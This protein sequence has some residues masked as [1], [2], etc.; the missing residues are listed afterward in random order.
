MNANNPT[1]RPI[2]KLL[3]ALLCTLVAVSLTTVAAAWFAGIWSSTVSFPVQTGGN[4]DLLPMTVWQYRA[5][6]EV[7]QD[8]EVMEWERHTHDS[9]I[10][11]VGYPIDKPGESLDAN[12]K[13]VVSELERLHFGR[14]DNLISLNEDNKIYFCFKLSKKEHGGKKLS[15]TFD[16]A[17]YGTG[18]KFSNDP[19]HSID[20][21]DKDGKLVTLLPDED[22]DDKID[23]NPPLQYYPNATTGTQSQMMDFLQFTYCV[24]PA[25]EVEVNFSLQDDSETK[26]TFLSGPDGADL[27]DIVFVADEAANNSYKDNIKEQALA[28]FN[29]LKFVGMNPADPTA[30]KPI[31]IGHGPEIKEGEEETQAETEKRYADQ[32]GDIDISGSVGTGEFYYLYICMTPNL[33]TY[34]LHEN[35]LEYFAQSYMFFDVTFAFEVQ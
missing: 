32:L 22:N 6:H 9:D 21:Y 35:I 30:D 8:D 12:G 25:S 1:K 11:Q 15:F 14:I 5:I 19:R 10:D 4:P 17:D 26:W 24:V 34:G 18:T 23:E 28:N 16:Y 7:N 31:Q 27:T 33:E 2:K 29:K 13:I 3:T 20:L